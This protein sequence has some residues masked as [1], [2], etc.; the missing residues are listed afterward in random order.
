MASI[1]AVATLGA[2][3]VDVAGTLPE[4]YFPALAP[5]LKAALAKS[6]RVLEREIEIE[7]QE[8]RELGANSARLPR[9]GGDLSYA[10]NRT[11]VSGQSG[12][13][14]R[15]D[16]LFYRLELSQSLFHWG[17]LRNET[18][19][20]RMATAIAEKN[21][22]EA[23]RLLAVAL[24]SGYVDLVATK[25]H[26]RQ[27][28]Q[29]QR[30]R[31]AALAT[32]QEKLASGTISPGHAERQKLAA[33]EA[34][35]GLGRAEMQ[36]VALCRA[37]ARLAG[38]AEFTE[39]NIPGLV[40][41]PVHSAGLAS[42][43]VAPL[44]REGGRSAFEAQ[45]HALNAQEAD[46]R[47][48]IARVRLLPKFNATAGY[49]LENTTNATLLNVTQQGVERQGFAINAQWSIFD[50]LAT[51]GA[52][53]EAL[54]AKR[55]AERRLATAAGEAVERVQNLQRLLEIE[56]EAVELAEERRGF[57]MEELERTRGEVELGNA[58]PSRIEQVSADLDQ[59]EAY[60]AMAR[61]NYLRVWSELVSLAGADPALNNLP[62]SHVRHQR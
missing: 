51:R 56:A 3:P 49:Y 21:Y 48:E 23:Y 32:D 52:R 7:E 55:L 1:L 31:E 54:A 9:L 14:Y 60:A 26:V 53:Q 17:A 11:A 38:L 44:L 41:K 36:L 59:Q 20:A 43:V 6:P 15:D 57:L 16:G 24:R 45:V 42:A 46:L 34:A 2:Q 27:L 18:E 40:P 10:Y 58:P 30:L 47:L 5:I 25:L 19:R 50:G 13:Q 4:D 8:A 12:I 33:R 29:R 39:T 28:R 61:A 35:L 37:F 22:A 62:A